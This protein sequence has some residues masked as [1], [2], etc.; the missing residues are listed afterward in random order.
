MA[1]ANISGDLANPQKAIPKGTLIA[2]AFTT[3]IY[4]LL[5]TFTGATTLRDADGL[6]L[7]TLLTGIWNTSIDGLGPVKPKSAFGSYFAPSCA[8]NGTC[9]YGLVCFCFN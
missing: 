5:V 6:H 9:S 1:G 4:L 2:I 8:A 7:P 3:V